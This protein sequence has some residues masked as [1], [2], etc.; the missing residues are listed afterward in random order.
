MSSYEQLAASGGETDHARGLARTRIEI[1]TE[2]HVP[3][4]PYSPIDALNRRAAA[5]GS[6]RIAGL[7]AHADYNGH[8]IIVQYNSYRGYYITEYFWAGRVV[9][10]RGTF[11]DCLSAAL[12]EH[13]RGALGSSVAVT[14]RDG[15]TEALARCAGEPRLVPGKESAR[16][17]YTWRHTIAAQ[18]GDSGFHG[19]PIFDWEL[20]QAADSEEAYSAAVKAKYDRVYER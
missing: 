5:T 8:A 16:D 4:R 10:S 17:W 20:L 14:V 1:M 13:D 3:T 12:A 11:A 19:R 6:L 7:S 18:A 15:D 2:F 9:L